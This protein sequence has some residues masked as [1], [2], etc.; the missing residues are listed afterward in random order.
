[1]IKKK[2]QEN[3]K[4]KNGKQSMRTKMTTSFLT[5]A[6]SFSEPKILKKKKKFLEIKKYRTREEDY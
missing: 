3:Q 2:G 4:D 6:V 5:L 1:M